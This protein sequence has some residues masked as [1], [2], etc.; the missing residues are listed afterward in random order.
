MALIFEKVPFFQV[1]KFR[2]TNSRLPEVYKL[3][4]NNPANKAKAEVHHDS[5][6]LG[7]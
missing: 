4:R 6:N 7:L 3:Q 1:M 5:G 2:N